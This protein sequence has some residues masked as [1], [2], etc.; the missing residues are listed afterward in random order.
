MAHT[1]P[2][3]PLVPLWVTFRQTKDAIFKS[4]ED[5]LAENGL[6][7]PKMMVLFVLYHAQPPVTAGAIARWLLK[8]TQSV[9]GLLARMEAGGL[10]RRRRDDETD[11]RRVIVEMTDRGRELFEQSRPIIAKEVSESF[12]AL[13]EDEL[14]QLQGLLER[15]RQHCLQQH[16]SNPASINEILQPQNHV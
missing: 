3:H 9:S 8:E 1:A 15:V 14:V 13:S 6:S 11:R 2:Y 5:T 7:F 16:G 12:T 10:V 4:V